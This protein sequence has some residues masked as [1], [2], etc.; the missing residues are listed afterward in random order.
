M[1][2]LS[3]YNVSDN[4]VESNCLLFMLGLFYQA[5]CRGYK[6]TSNREAGKGRFDLKIEPTEKANFKTGIY[7][8]FKVLKKH[9]KNKKLQ[10]S[11]KDALKQIKDKHYFSDLPKFTEQ[12]V[13]CG[14]AFQGKDVYI[15]GEVL[16]QW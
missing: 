15:M 4:L 3:Y 11:A 12:C 9:S 10:N 16:N 8:E 7:M 1:N 2:A 6:I 13:I 5:H 14:I